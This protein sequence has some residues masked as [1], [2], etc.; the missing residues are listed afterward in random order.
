MMEKEALN[1]ILKFLAVYPIWKEE[2]EIDLRNVMILDG[3][4]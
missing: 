4:S 2:G 3:E 1:M